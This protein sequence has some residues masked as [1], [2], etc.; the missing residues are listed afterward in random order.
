[1]IVVVSLAVKFAL[2]TIKIYFV[3]SLN[4]CKNSRAFVVLNCIRYKQ[5]ITRSANEQFDLS[6][7]SI[8]VK[9][10]VLQQ[11]I[12]YSDTDKTEKQI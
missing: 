3:I 5:R 1:M 10:R 11:K 2:K 7:L 12:N 8:K 4:F 9:R 6:A